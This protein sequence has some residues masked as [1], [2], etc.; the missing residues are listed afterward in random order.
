MLIYRR[1]DDRSITC[2]EWINPLI[3][4]A[5]INYP[6]TIVFLIGEEG[7][8]HKPEI[9]HEVCRILLCSGHLHSHS[10]VCLIW[11]L[12]Q[13]FAR[14]PSSLIGIGNDACETGI[15][16]I[17]TARQS[18][19]RYKLVFTS[20]CAGFFDI[21]KRDGTAFD[22]SLIIRLVGDKC[23]IEA[24]IIAHRCIIAK[25]DRRTVVNV[26]LGQGSHLG[27]IFTILIN[28]FRICHN[29]YLLDR[30]SHIKG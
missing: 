30:R 3:I 19:I 10:I 25:R 18:V 27:S 7:V 13:E 22:L 12:V 26:C 2:G 11:Q 5:C 15:G 24:D 9:L 14:D 8:F 4:E 20:S 21:S 17:F 16:L 1:N 23:G 6:L 29:L 28:I